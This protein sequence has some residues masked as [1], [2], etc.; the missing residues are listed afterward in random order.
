MSRRE[1]TL[2]PINYVE[3]ETPG[4]ENTEEFG[5]DRTRLLQ[6]IRGAVPEGGEPMTY[7]QLRWILK[8]RPPR[9]SSQDSVSVETDSPSLVRRAALEEN[10]T[11]SDAEIIPDSRCVSFTY[12]ELRK[13][14]ELVIKERQDT[15]TFGKVTEPAPK[16]LGELTK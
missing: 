12:P 2:Y 4:K 7:H 14:V 9:N 11:L 8:G 5:R 3:P 6:L 16:E 13:A 15:W 1:K 10:Q